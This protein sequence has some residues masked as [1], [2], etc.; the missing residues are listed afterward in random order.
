M[1]SMSS[2]TLPDG[3]EIWI[4]YDGDCPFC[5]RF[6]QMYRLREQFGRVHLVDARSN[7][8]ILAEIRALGLD[9]DQG[10]ALKMDGRFYH[11]ADCMNRLALMG[12]RSSAFNHLNRWI[13]RSPAIARALYPALVTGRNLTLRLLGRKPINQAF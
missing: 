9:L 6:M 7:D 4:V 2:K 12:S 13:F 10:M 3:D 5:S 8:P 1:S 11:G